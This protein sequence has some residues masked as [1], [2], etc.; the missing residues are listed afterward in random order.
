MSSGTRI[1]DMNLVQLGRRCLPG[2]PPSCLPA[3][4]QV[5]R[6]RTCLPAGRDN[7]DTNSSIRINCENHG[8]F[9]ITNLVTGF[10][11]MLCGGL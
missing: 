11:K 4:R 7:Q 2:S 1:Q 9:S 8:V 10:L 5:G 6:A 3:G